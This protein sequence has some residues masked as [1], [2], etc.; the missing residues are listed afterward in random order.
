[1]SNVRPLMRSLEKFLLVASLGL[2]AYG[3]F[4]LFGGL[5]SGTLCY[6]TSC[7]HR[8]NPAE[9]FYEYAVVYGGL[10]AFGL[11]SAWRSLKNLRTVLGNE[12]D[13]KDQV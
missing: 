6:Q 3:A 1:M 4:M 5:L 7:A 12:R 13:L 10:I 11:A 2:A 9:R 8:D